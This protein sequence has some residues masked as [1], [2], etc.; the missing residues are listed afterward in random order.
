M[1][2]DFDKEA[3]PKPPRQT[4][5]ADKQTALP[6]PALILSK[7]FY[8]SVDLPVTTFRGVVDSIRAQNRSVYYHQKFRRV[9]DLTECVHGDYLCYY[10]AEMQWRRDFKVDQEIVKVIQERMRACQQ[11]EGHSYEQN[12]SKEI[13]QFNEVSNSYMS[14]YGDLGAY[15]SGRKCLMKQKERMMAAQA[16]SAI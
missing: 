6:N 13:E 10:E 5:V 9:P 4:P 7:L 15:S 16:Q 14:R 12:C 2:A 1:P 3:Y 8:Y 11:R